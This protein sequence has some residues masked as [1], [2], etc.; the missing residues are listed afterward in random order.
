MCVSAVLQ[1]LKLAAAE[2]AQP[3]ASVSFQPADLSCLLTVAANSSSSSSSTSNTRS[4]S[5]SCEACVQLWRLDKLWDRH[6]LQ[7]KTLQLPAS[8]L[9]VCHAW[10]PEVRKQHICY[11]CINAALV[12]RPYLTCP[13]CILQHAEQEQRVVTH[14]AKAPSTVFAVCVV[15]LLLAGNLLWLHKWYHC[16]HRP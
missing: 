13:L 8:C 11:Q 3:V 1:G 15:I 16:L 4:N 2:L 6:D 12:H 10:A 14:S 7:A 9:A 5:K